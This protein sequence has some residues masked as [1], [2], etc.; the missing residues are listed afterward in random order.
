MKKIIMTLILIIAFSLVFLQSSYAEMKKEGTV[1]GTIF[2][3]GSHEI[4][5]LD[6]EH[7]VLT[8]EN[9]GVR[10]TDSKDGPFHGMSTHN[11][12]VIYFENGVGR[13]KGY[14]FSTD[15]DGDK[16]IIEL[17]ENAAQLSPKQT[18]GTGEII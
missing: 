3:A 15:K 2:Y 13:T 18:T 6:K 5:P 1:S 16:I 7:F 17:T 4:T 9:F 11:L 14:I 10:I 8:Y 12:G